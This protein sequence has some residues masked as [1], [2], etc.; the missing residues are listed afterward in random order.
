MKTCKKC[1]WCTYLDGN[2][3]GTCIPPKP[4]WSEDI[5]KNE[6][7]FINSTEAEKCSCFK[8]RKTE[9]IIADLLRKLNKFTRKEFYLRG[10]LDE[11]VTKL[12]TARGIN[13]VNYNLDYKEITKELDWMLKSD[14]DNRRL[15]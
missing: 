15:R 4:W 13:P 10:V 9:S 8:D 14:P 11:I 6:S 3:Y 1:E 5:I 12:A 2:I 7:V